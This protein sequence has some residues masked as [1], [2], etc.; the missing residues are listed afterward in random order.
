MIRWIAKQLKKKVKM[1]SKV[2]GRDKGE[3]ES[4]FNLRIQGSAHPM[5]EGTCMDTEIMIF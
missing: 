4:L 2:T 3:G 5:A 1:T